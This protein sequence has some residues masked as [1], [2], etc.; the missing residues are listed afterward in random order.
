MYDTNC[1]Q[2]Y[3]VVYTFLIFEPNLIQHEIYLEHRLIYR[4][5]DFSDILQ[6]NCAQNKFTGKIS[7]H[8]WFFYKRMVKFTSRKS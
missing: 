1:T 2:I 5:V 4:K 7:L 6:T 3:I 8:L